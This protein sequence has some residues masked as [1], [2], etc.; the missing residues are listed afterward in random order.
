M[1]RPNP[2]RRRPDRHR[3]ERGGMEVFYAGVVLI[4][5]L[6]I[7]LVID[8]GLALDSLSDADYLAQEAA[9][10]GAQQI[11]PAQA[12]TGQ[13]IVVDPDAAQATARDFLTRAGVDG[14]VTVSADGQ[15]LTVTVHDVHHPYFASLIGVSRMPVTGHGTAT[16][17]H[18]AGG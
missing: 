4:G 3:R 13:S 17:L 6:F 10:A 8:G 14:D 18:Q 7:G 16:L 1:S 5:F 2:R 15:H 9:R 11:D 12:I